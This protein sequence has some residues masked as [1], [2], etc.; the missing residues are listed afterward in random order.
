MRP[1]TP[2]HVDESVSAEPSITRLEQWH[3]G[4]AENDCTCH[5]GDVDT[6]SRCHLEYLSGENV[7]SNRPFLEAESQVI[8]TDEPESSRRVSKT[9]STMPSKAAAVSPSG[10]A[11]IL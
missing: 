10:S 1:V 5:P 3:H 6:S 9:F 7:P 8:L 11:T 2:E 4:Y